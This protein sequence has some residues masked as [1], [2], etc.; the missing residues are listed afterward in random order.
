MSAHELAIPLFVGFV[1]SLVVYSLAVIG[2]LSVPLFFVIAIG[3]G[4]LSA[5]LVVLQAH[6]DASGSKES[7]FSYF[8]RRLT[9]ASDA[10]KEAR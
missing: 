3:A 1:A 4:L 2:W 5:E 7:A 9:G 6:L 10:D 8:W